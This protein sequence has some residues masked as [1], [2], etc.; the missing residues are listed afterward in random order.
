VPEQL[1]GRSVP[2]AASAAATV[3]ALPNDRARRAVGI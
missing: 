1:G 2:A 3:D